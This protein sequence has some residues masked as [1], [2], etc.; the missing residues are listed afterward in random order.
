MKDPKSLPKVPSDFMKEFT[1]RPLDADPP[2]AWDFFAYQAGV[3]QYDTEQAMREWQAKE[4]LLKEFMGDHHREILLRALALTSGLSESYVRAI[5]ERTARPSVLEAF[6]LEA[7]ARILG[8][9]TLD[10]MQ[11]YCNAFSPHP[12]FT[13]FGK[14]IFAVNIVRRYAGKRIK[15]HFKLL[16]TRIPY[17][18]AKDKIEDIAIKWM[19]KVRNVLKKNPL[20]NYRT[21]EEVMEDEKR[22]KDSFLSALKTHDEEDENYVTD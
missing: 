21:I 20:D 5:Q 1:R 2:L 19:V 17:R 7:A 6:Y 3:S 14:N 18:A 22:S 4:D 9:V 16:M 8:M 12:F 15:Q 11:F 10:A 13:P